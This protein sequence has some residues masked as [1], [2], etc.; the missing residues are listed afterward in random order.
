MQGLHVY[1]PKPI[2]YVDIEALIPVI[3]QSGVQ[4]IVKVLFNDISN[5]HINSWSR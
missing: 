1:Q 4:Q 3:F 5:S 2:Q